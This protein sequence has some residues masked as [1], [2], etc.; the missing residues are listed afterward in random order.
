MSQP[1]FWKNVKM[2][3]TF[4]KWGLWNPLGLP[5][6]QNSIARVKKPRLEAFF[7][8][9]EIYRSVDVENDLAWTIWT[10]AT[11]VMAKRRA[12]SQIGSLT[13][14]HYKS[15]IDPTPVWADGMWHTIGKLSRRTTSLLHTSSQSEVWAKSYELAKSRESKPR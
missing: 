11:Q 9:L 15:G 13:L 5:K 12:E 3:L 6:L 14:D 7:T 4:P 1:H 10:L 8:S 2:T